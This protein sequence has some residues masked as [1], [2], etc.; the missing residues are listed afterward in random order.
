MAVG[1]E[2]QPGARVVREREFVGRKLDLAEVA[3]VIEEVDRF[4]MRIPAGIL[5]P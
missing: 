5:Y 1:D 2:R 3:E 4:E